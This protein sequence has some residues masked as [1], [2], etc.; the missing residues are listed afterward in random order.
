MDEI[1]SSN[2]NAGFGAVSLA[3]FLSGVF[4][5]LGAKHFGAIRRVSVGE[6]NQ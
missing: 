3:I 4:W 5:L 1:V 6:I 2:M